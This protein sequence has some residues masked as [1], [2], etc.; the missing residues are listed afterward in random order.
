VENPDL[1]R[2][3]THAV[4]A[5]TGAAFIGYS[6]RGHQLRVVYFKGAKLFPPAPLARRVV[7][8]AA[9]PAAI[10]AA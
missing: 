4:G 8:R 10:P 3:F 7:R 9:A 2:I 5:R 6:P 1:A